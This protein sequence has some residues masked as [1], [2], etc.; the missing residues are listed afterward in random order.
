MMQTYVNIV[1]IGLEQALSFKIEHISG[2]LSV[3]IEQDNNK[4]NRAVNFV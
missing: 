1:C 2:S 4:D 3:N